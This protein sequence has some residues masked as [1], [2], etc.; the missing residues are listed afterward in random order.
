VPLSKA[1]CV[2]TDLDWEQFYEAIKQ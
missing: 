1:G 2:S